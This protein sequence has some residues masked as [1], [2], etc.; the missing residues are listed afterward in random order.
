MQWE[1]TILGWVKTYALCLVV[2]FLIERCEPLTPMSTDHNLPVIEHPSNRSTAAKPCHSLSLR[3]RCT[4]GCCELHHSREQSQ[5]HGA[6]MS[7]WAQ[8]LA[9]RLPRPFAHRCSSNNIASGRRIPVAPSASALKHGWEK[10]PS[11]CHCF[12]LGTRLK[13]CWAGS[14]ELLKIRPTAVTSTVCMNHWGI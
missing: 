3:S 2:H 4:V 12:L 10:T 8:R 5:Q 7:C 13:S 1:G 14:G 6:E 9:A 11:W